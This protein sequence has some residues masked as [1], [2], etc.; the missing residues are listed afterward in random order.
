MDRVNETFTRRMGYIESRISKTALS[1]V[2]WPVLSLP[3]IEIAIFMARFDNPDFHF[4]FPSEDFYYL[5]YLNAFP[6][7]VLDAMSSPKIL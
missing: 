5:Y 6:H 4:N 7:A 2:H 1:Q 3:A